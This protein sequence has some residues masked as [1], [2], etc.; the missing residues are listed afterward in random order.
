MATYKQTVFIVDDDEP[1]RS[2]LRLLMKSVGHDA[3]TFT[4]GDEFLA[5][6]K[7]GISGCLVLDIRMPGMSGLEL[8]EKLREQGVNIPIIFITGHGD[9]PMAVQ[10][11]K[12]GAMEFLQKPFREQ[13]LIDRV[14][15][16]LEKNLNVHKLA[17]QRTEIKQRVTKL[18]P[19]ERQ[20]MDMI[21]QGKASKVIAIDLGVSQRTV[22]T[23]RTRIMRKMQAKSLAELVKTA[24]RHQD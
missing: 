6:C 23:H 7:P 13:D 11:M 20:I 14:N 17:L 2:A 1:V 10:A 9:V 24:V 5:S 12:H 8:Q 16:A 15:E 4:S 3:M 18:T 19:R 21:V 22:D